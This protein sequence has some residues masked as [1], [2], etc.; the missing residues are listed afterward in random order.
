MDFCVFSV[1]HPRRSAGVSAWARLVAVSLGSSR[2]SLSLQVLGGEGVVVK[3]EGVQDADGT[4][5]ALEDGRRAGEQEAP[6]EAM[7]GFGQVSSPG[8]E[9]GAWDLSAAF[10]S[11]R[12]ELREERGGADL[13][14]RLPYP[15]GCAGNICHALARFA[16]KVLRAE[17][18]KSDSRARRRSCGAFS[19]QVM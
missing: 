6:Q 1:G 13:C 15:A 5:Y 2:G 3:D 11:E 18:K 14:G 9:A 7:A 17:R 19:T 16:P 10:P 4:V 8:G 12:L